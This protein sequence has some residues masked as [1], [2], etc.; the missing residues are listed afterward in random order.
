VVGDDPVG[1]P[2]PAAVPVWSVGIV[3]T[4]AQLL[5][6]QRRCEQMYGV[7]QLGHGLLPTPSEESVAEPAA[8]LTFAQRRERAEIAARNLLLSRLWVCSGDRDGRLTLWNA[9]TTTPVFTVNLP[10]TQILSRQ[11]LCAPRLS[12][13]FPCHYAFESLLAVHADYVS[14]RLIAGCF[15]GSLHVIDATTGSVLKTIAV[16]TTAPILCCDVDWDAG[17][18]AWCVW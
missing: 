5:S 12:E 8:R 14:K 4:T 1:H 15:D 10:V 6:H 9:V 2:A 18:V 17:I 13:R 3:D 7:F 11:S 16:G